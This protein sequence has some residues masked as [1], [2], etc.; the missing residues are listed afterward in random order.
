MKKAIT[1][2]IPYLVSEDKNDDLR[3]AL[4]SIEKHM[5]SEVNVVLVGEAP[6][7]INLKEVAVVPFQNVV[8]EGFRKAGNAWFR[9]RAILAAEE[10]SEDFILMHDDMVF[11][12]ETSAEDVAKLVYAIN[13]METK[14]EPNGKH[15][16]LIHRTMVALKK[17]GASTYNFENHSPRMFNKGKIRLLRPKYKAKQNRLLLSTLYFNEYL[18]ELIQTKTKK[19]KMFKKGDHVKAGFYGEVSDY[20]HPS[21]TEE[22]VLKSM[23]QK[24]FANWNDAGLTDALKTVLEG[25]FPDKSKF[26]K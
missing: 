12:K 11:L 18:E 4:R 10:I 13:T 15:A 19:P 26:E 14:P 7:W 21:S 22:E 2:M 16:Q 20:S 5:T 17:Q 23:K 24:R 3:M 8:T 6:D 25:L 1:I 9:M